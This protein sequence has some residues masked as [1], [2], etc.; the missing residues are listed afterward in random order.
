MEFLMTDIPQGF[1]INER[2]GPFTN[3]N[4]PFYIKKDSDRWT[5]GA[6]ILDRHCNAANIAHGGMLMSFADGVLGHTVYSKTKRAGVTIKFNSEF[7]SAAR[8]GEWLEGYGDVSRVRG[9][10][11][12][13]NTMLKVSTRNVLSVTSIFKLRK[14]EAL[15]KIITKRR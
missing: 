6:F 2:R 9:D 13:C 12:Y 7:L 11:V 3:H 15:K 14:I 5:H 8:E 4:G 1:I 10:Y